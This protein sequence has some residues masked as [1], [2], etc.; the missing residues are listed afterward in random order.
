[1]TA[2]EIGP[3]PVDFPSIQPHVDSQSRTI[4]RVD[5]AESVFLELSKAEMDKQAPTLFLFLYDGI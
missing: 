3:F 4:W 2:W 1:M 5:L